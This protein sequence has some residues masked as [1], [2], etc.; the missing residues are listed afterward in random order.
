MSAPCVPCRGTGRTGIDGRM[1][2]PHCGGRG[3]SPA[4]M[5]IAGDGPYGETM[6][7]KWARKKVRRPSTQCAKCGSRR[8]SRAPGSGRARADR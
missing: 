1:P 5:D 2:C 8:S 4:D 7:D 3:T 6:R